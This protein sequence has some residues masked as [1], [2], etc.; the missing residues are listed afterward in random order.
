[1]K[2]RIPEKS[3]KNYFFINNEYVNN[4]GKKICINN[5]IRICITA[6]KYEKNNFICIGVLHEVD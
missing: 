2:I 5:E 4:N 1:M 6:I 3:M